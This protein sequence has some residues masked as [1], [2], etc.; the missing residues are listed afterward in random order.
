MPLTEVSDEKNLG[1]A[2]GVRAI[3]M[4]SSGEPTHMP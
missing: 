4:L 3:T 1:G 2:C